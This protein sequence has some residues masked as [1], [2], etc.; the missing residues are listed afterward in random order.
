MFIVVLEDITLI[1]SVRLSLCRA[2]SLHSI[3]SCVKTLTNNTL[4]LGY[5]K[6]SNAAAYSVYSDVFYAVIHLQI[7]A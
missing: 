3:N 2:T 1:S 7:L 4:K 6:D 5:L